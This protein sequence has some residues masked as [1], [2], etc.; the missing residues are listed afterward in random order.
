VNSEKL[1]KGPWFS[2]FL[3]FISICAT[4]AGCGKWK[5]GG[6]VGHQRSDKNVK[7]DEFKVKLHLRREQSK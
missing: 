4:L 6:D 2:T 5:R 3:L 1:R 7:A